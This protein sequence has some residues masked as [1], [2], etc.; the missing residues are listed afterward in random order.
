MNIL[1]KLG[2]HRWNYKA[3][4]SVRGISQEVTRYCERCERIE[5][6]INIIGLVF[7]P[8]IFTEVVNK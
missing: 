6:G 4:V 2:F 3:K 8:H 5:K 1:C 7:Q